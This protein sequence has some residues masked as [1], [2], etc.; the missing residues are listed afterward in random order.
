MEGAGAA[1]PRKRQK[2][3]RRLRE[4]GAVSDRPRADGARA[5]RRLRSAGQ[6]RRSRARSFGVSGTRIRLETRRRRFQRR[7]LSPFSYSNFDIPAADVDDTLHRRLEARSRQ[8]EK[9]ALSAR[10]QF[11]E[12]VC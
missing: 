9:G 6:Q 10:P 5:R 3:N 8:V 11:A 4:A 2:V 12:L 7:T 1:A